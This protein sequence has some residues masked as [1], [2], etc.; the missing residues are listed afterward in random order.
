M[1]HGNQVVPGRRK[2]RKIHDRPPK[3]G[4]D[5]P[6]PVWLPLML[7]SVLTGL[8][9]CAAMGQAPPE[10]HDDMPLLNE[11]MQEIE[12]A[13]LLS[14]A[15]FTPSQLATLLKLQGSYLDDATAIPVVQDA[16]RELAVSIASGVP[17]EE[18]AARLGEVHQQLREAG[19]RARQSE[20]A[21]S[22]ELL[23][24]LTPDQKKA[25]V[26]SRSPL[27]G[28]KQVVEALGRARKAPDEAWQTFRAHVVDAITRTIARN[29][30]HP[31]AKKELA[32]WLD[33][34][35]AMSDEEFATEA[36]G[37]PAAWGEALMPELMK[38]LQDPRVQKERLLEI[39]RQLITHP[40]G[41]DIV[42]A[43]ID[44]LPTN[45]AAKGGQETNNADD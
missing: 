33:A 35:R 3:Q 42:E 30:G 38:R 31:P 40:K 13:K 12:Y 15:R 21:L 41:Y 29:G 39:C 43:V 18:A 9:A 34:V 37:L 7:L 45:T 23:S 32:G 14:S 11:L 10:T 5:S 22:R 20:Q 27:G 44:R 36:P 25:L 26:I 28:L 19:E 16:C 2:A 4:V 8:L 24:A 1:K 17:P 6:K